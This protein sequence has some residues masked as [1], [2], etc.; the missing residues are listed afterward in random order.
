MT[1]RNISGLLLTQN[2]VF[3]AACTN[4]LHYLFGIPFWTYLNTGSLLLLPL[5]HCD[6]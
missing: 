1:L 3:L 5:L 6:E 4:R 2:A